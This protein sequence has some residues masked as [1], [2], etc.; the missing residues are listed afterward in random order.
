MEAIRQMSQMADLQKKLNQDTN[1][2]RQQRQTYNL[3]E[4]IRLSEQY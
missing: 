4:R 3:A 2:W 1:W